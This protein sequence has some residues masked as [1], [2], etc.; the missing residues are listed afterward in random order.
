MY[1]YLP[2]TSN[3][4]DQFFTPQEINRHPTFMRCDTMIRDTFN[5]PLLERQKPFDVDINNCGKTETIYPNGASSGYNSLKNVDVDSELKRIN[6]RADK[7]YYNNYKLDPLGRDAEVS[8]SPLTC[9][10]NIFKINQTQMYKK[11]EE[12]RYIDRNDTPKPCIEFQKFN[13]CKNTPI[14]SQHLELYDF[15]ADTKYCAQYPCQRLFH[16]VTKRNMYPSPYTPQDINKSTTTVDYSNVI[17]QNK[18][19][20][21]KIDNFFKTDPTCM[22]YA[23]AIDVN[24]TSGQCKSSIIEWEYQ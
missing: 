14:R 5:T 4:L 16:N 13:L 8:N 10:K 11:S 21:T 22:D 9:H 24:S 15:N 1:T 12:N 7:C 18:E 19:S 23:P 6:H 3:N 17:H 20:Q 2:P